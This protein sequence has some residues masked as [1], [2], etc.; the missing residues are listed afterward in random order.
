M[1]DGIK[2]VQSFTKSP[3]VSVLRKEYKRKHLAM[4]GIHVFSDDV[5][6]LHADS[7][8]DRCQESL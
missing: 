4:N 8:Q 3:T 7:I 6:A 1:S 5:I 2:D